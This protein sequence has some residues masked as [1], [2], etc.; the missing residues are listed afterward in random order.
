MI[1]V[2]NCTTLVQLKAA[3]PGQNTHSINTDPA[4]ASA[5]G[6]LAVNYQVPVASTLPGITIAG[7]AYDYANTLRAA[8]PTIGAY[9]KGL[10]SQVVTFTAM[11]AKT[12]GAADFTPVVAASSGLAITSY[13]SSNTAVATVNSSSGLVHIVGAGIANI[14]A[15][16][17]GNSTWAAASASSSLTVNAK[18]LTLASAA[19]QNKPYDGTNA[20]VLT[21]TLSGVINSDNVTVSK[22]GT[23]ATINVGTG[24]AVT[25][26]STLGG[27]KAGNYSLTQ[28]T[29]LTANITAGA[30]TITFGALAAETYGDAP[31]VVSAT[32]GASGNAVTFSSSDVTVASCTGTTGSTV[33]ILKA[34]SC[35]IYADQAGNPNY[36]AATQVAQTL[37][38]AKADQ[39][40]TLSPLPVGS[41]SLYAFGS[42]IQVT[43]TCTSGL[44]VAI[45]LG[46][47]SA[48]TLNGSNQ[49]INVG[50]T[51]TV[52]INLSAAANDNYNAASSSY[53]FDVV[54][55]N[56]TITFDALAGVT[57]TPGLTVALSG[58]AT[59]SSA[60]AVT[61]SV[62][63]GPATITGTTLNISGA[64]E[65]VVAASQAGDAS[66]NPAADVTQTLTVS[67]ATQT[68][69][70]AALATK[71]YGD[72]A[73][74]LSALGGG[75]G[76]AVTF[77]SSDPT[78]AS[79]DGTNGATVTILKAGS[80]SIY[81][82]QA[83]NSSYTAAAQESQ[84]LTINKEEQTLT[85]SPLPIGN[86]PLKDFTDPIQV[87]ATSTSGLTVTI[88][89]S[90]GS[91][92]NLNGSNQLE[93]IGQTGTVV[94]NLSQDGDEYYNSATGSYTFDVVKSN[95]SIS[96]DALADK[97][98]GDP[99]YSPGATA[100]SALSVSYTS[101]NTAV[102]TIV[103][104]QIHI[105]GVG[106][107]TITA[108]QDGDATWNPALNVSQALKVL[109]SQTITFG[110]LAAKTYGDAPFSLTGS[111][112]SGL[113]VA[114]S[115]SN[116]NVAT[117]SG[118]AVTI[119][120][121][122][123]ANITA[124]QAGDAYYSAAADII[125]LL[126]VNK[127]AQTITFGALSAK[128][129]GD[130]N[131][132]PG[133]TSATSGINA[134]TY[135][136][137]NTDVATIVSGQIHIVGGGTSNITASQAA[138]TNYIAA[139]DV[140][141]ELTVNQATQ[142]IT[143]GALAAKTYGDADYS[144]GATAS[145]GL[146]VNYSSSNTAVAT[147]VGNQIHIVGAGTSNITA[148]QAGNTNYSAA[149][150][151]IQGLTVNALGL[152]WT[153]NTNSDWNTSTN[154][155][156]NTI[157]TSGYNCSIPASMPHNPTVNELPSLPAICNN[158]SIASGA[159]VTIASGKALTVN[160]TLVNQGGNDNLLI[161]SGGSL[162][163]NTD[164][165]A[166]TVKQTIE[167]SA[168]LSALKYHFV[169]IPTQYAAPT[170]N[171]F[172]GS[173]IYKLDPLQQ[174]D[175][176]TNPAYGNWVGL[177]TSTTTPL[178]MNQGYM[179][180]Y[181]GNS[182]DYAFTGNL[183]NGT[184]NY[185]LAGH[186]GTN[187]YTY[188]L[189]PNPYPSSLVWN[190]AN[191]A[192]TKSAGI[193]G[194]CY[195]W[196]AASGN[197]TNLASSATS[198]IP[199]GQAM[200]VLVV[201]EALPTLSVNNNARSHSS[202]AFYKSGGI[203]NQFTVNATCNN[204]A[205]VTVVKYSQEATESFD[206]QVDGMKILGLEDAPQLYTLSANQ[207]YSINNLP[208]LTGYKSVPMN[209]ETT[210][211]G[212][213][214]FSFSG[215]ESFPNTLALKLEDKLTNQLINL[216]QQPTYTFAHQTSNAKDRFVLHFGSATG[217]EEPQTTNG[218]I[219]ISGKTVN[220][221]SPASVGEKALVEIFNAAGQ[222]VFSKQITL[223]QLTKVP[224]N[225]SG[226]AVVRVSTEKDVWVAKG[227]F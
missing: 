188:N 104:N 109:S 22:T 54:K 76:N 10:F 122:G 90:G 184:F 93:N 143:F 159:F 116:T 121:A 18:T 2:T 113:T 92:A 178:M 190:T 194:T 125:Q 112:S 77:S 86:Q 208:E 131:F 161:G 147:I 141:Q 87:T 34:G 108:S 206:L 168:N 163:H 45:S 80:C 64:G 25:S 11:T 135:T 91:A 105:T 27:T 26:T 68:I 21:G 202:Q 62:V 30:Q 74:T 146:T 156:P 20:A 115:S 35:S 4:F 29:G 40:I 171:L 196:N 134:I 166:A 44:T 9:E 226:F 70:F 84:T 100:N 185:S 220:I 67:Q 60:L 213:V 75:S 13:T 38:I 57:Y 140:I 48:A 85:L 63:S 183:N 114:Y 117:V 199:V 177:G 126:T 142:S 59:A 204:Y 130:A 65:V 43:A 198:Y 150:D 187:V 154:W 152:S 66:W 97:A 53:T 28:P 83:G 82:D 214:S 36:G 106:T 111:A 192:W 207:K 50:S 216:R 137:S 103:S 88:F 56:Q 39:V 37:T 23:F 215:I 160:G 151:V 219:W 61:Y 118:S 169:A 148:S 175:P 153:G 162:L 138:S 8:T 55:S 101:S 95:Q 144:P 71:N 72:A 211:A 102:A 200:M 78:M 19:A 145:S 225:L 164:Y 174:I 110:A 69:T 167:G 193:G 170:A 24:I 81:A 89:L 179:I 123:T 201:N 217:I 1:G 120:Q 203:E 176:P 5:G 180:Y 212:N 132:A 15:T 51:G 94:I 17:A 157:P 52:V 129:Y 124:S 181:P 98:T 195:I 31:F 221:S 32:G 191:A 222:V 16:Q 173:Y 107:T 205:D 42:P 172:V 223:S 133:A 218:N 182:H 14:T 41:V 189:I 49:L 6:T 186:S 197:Y 7:F 128:T 209:F 99:N 155:S 136:S 46:A 119:L 127:A 3:T 158:L 73:F 47:G 33:T 149:S 165:V 224:T 210:F 96:F 139:T 58:K 12:Y 227:I 79:C